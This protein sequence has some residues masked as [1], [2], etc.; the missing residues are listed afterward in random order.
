MIDRE[1]NARVGGAAVWLRSWPT[2][3]QKPGNPPHTRA[4]LQREVGFNAAGSIHVI[5]AV[6]SAR[7]EPSSFLRAQDEPSFFGEDENGWRV[8]A[9]GIDDRSVYNGD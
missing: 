3:R 2:F 1:T 5:L 9:S 7:V 4:V 8:T 6:D